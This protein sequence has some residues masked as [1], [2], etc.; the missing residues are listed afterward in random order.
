MTYNQKRSLKLRFQ[1]FGF[2]SA[3]LI[4]IV[5]ILHAIYYVLPE[6]D[7]LFLFNLMGMACYLFTLIK[8]NQVILTKNI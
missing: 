3:H 4:F 1:Q 2:I 6:S 5:W 8:L 7:Q